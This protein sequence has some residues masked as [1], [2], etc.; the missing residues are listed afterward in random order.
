MLALKI[1]HDYTE[2]PG[3]HAWPY[4]KNSIKHQLLFFRS[5]F[6]EMKIRKP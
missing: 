6:D 5:Y 1:P 2:R 3:G 4:W